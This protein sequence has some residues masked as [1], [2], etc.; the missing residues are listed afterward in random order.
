MALSRAEMIQILGS[1]YPFR[2]LDPGV[3]ELVLDDSTLVEIEEGEKIYT[4]G[5]SAVKLYFI[6][7]GSLSLSVTER[8]VIYPIASLTTGDLFGYESLTG[9]AVRKTS[10]IANESTSVLEFTQE[11][12]VEFAN[13]V[14]EMLDALELLQASFQLLARVDLPW[15]GEK[16]NVS[17]IARRH[18]AFL[19]LRLLLPLGV[20]VLAVP[21]PLYLAASTSFSFL[22]PMIVLFVILLGIA[23]WALWEVL[24]WSNDYAIITNQ[25]IVFQERVVL[26]YDS[27]QE[28]PMNAVLSVNTETSQIGRMLDFGNV[29]VKTYA[30]T[31]V[32]PNL[33]AYAQVAKMVEAGMFRAVQT[34]TRGEHAAVERMLKARLSGQDQT[35][36][37]VTPG[38]S[39]QPVQNTGNSQGWLANLFQMRFEQGSTITY[40]KHWFLLLANIFVPSLVLLSL[41]VLV[42]L[43]ILGTVTLL[44][45][46]SVLFL[47]FFIGILGLAWWIYQYI[48]WRDD[49]YLVTDEQILDVYRKPLGREQ[50]KTAPLKNVQSI[51]FERKGLL[52]LLFNYGTVYVKVGDSN[53]TFDDVYNPAEVQ[54]ELFKRLAEREYRE[55]Q[56][57]IRADEQRLTE[58]L[59]IYDQVS[60]DQENPNPPSGI[61]K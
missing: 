58:W 17:Y 33:K 43:R 1:V 4:Q 21:V 29:L 44:S 50:K 14:P 38:A 36:E 9:G 61:S 30:G 35:A 24:D 45:T 13:C 57:S 48:D 27:R 12:I 40:R 32:L 2:K 5:D 11:Q 60:K 56:R 52:G 15:L 3:I 55:R 53:L 47:A 18:T 46:G 25:R 49:Y 10:A 37:N 39:A 54:R 59:Q 34:R 41:L 6:L 7:E 26:L 51:E 23:G 28:A 31:I 16:E 19:F 20:L 8:K 22:T 42:A